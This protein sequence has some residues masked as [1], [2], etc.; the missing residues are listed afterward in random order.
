VDAPLESF[1]LGNLVLAPVALARIAGPIVTKQVLAGGHGLPFGILRDAIQVLI[2]SQEYLPADDR[3]GCGECVV[4]LV[5]SQRFEDSAPLKDQT[6]P[7]A[8]GKINPTGRAD[9]RGV[10]DAQSVQSLPVYM[11]LASLG[12]QAG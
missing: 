7:V 5:D 3:R 4:E 11:D 1:V 2:A 6:R 12:A 9:R 10:Y 8:A